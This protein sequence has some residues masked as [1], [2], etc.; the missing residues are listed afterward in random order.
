LISG[1]NE[2]KRDLIRSLNPLKT[3]KT[4]IR[5]MVPMATPNSEIKEIMFIAVCDFLA[6]RYLFVIKKGNLKVFSNILPPV[7]HE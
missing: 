7:Y 5:D 3:D 6:F 2:L 4:T 1:S